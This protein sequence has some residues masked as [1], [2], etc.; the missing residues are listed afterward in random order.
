MAVSFYPLFNEILLVIKIHVTVSQTI[1]QQVSL[2][3]VF[4]HKQFESDAIY[5]SLI[6]SQSSVVT[7][8]QEV[9][10]SLAKPLLNFNGGLAKL[11]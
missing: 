9:N 5:I 8:G 3:L 6:N 4:F 2:Q 10:P 7:F 11:G 1:K